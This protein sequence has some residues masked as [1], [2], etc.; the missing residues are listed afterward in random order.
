MNDTQL[1]I[2]AIQGSQ[3]G[4]NDQVSK[5]ADTL[6]T[7]NGNVIELN[8]SMNHHSDNHS[9][10]KDEVKELT[11][12]LDILAHKVTTL[13]LYAKVRNDRRKWW[14]SNWHKIL[15]TVIICCSAVSAVAIFY[16]NN[17]PA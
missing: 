7:L 10:L 14:S 16:S 17:L 8:S 4:F 6:N 13:E 3:Q 1:I 2:S 9:E 5:L 12:Q 11:I 15:G